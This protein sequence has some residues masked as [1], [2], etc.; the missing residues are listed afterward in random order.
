M[1]FFL[2]LLL[3]SY[4][5]FFGA[6]KHHQNAVLS[7]VE[8]RFLKS[9][10]VTTVNYYPSSHTTWLEVNGVKQKL[11]SSIPYTPASI[12]LLPSTTKS[13][14]VTKT[15][16]V[17]DLTWASSYLTSAEYLQYLRKQGYRELLS[18]QTSTYN[19]S[20]WELGSKVKRVLIQDQVLMVGYLSPHAL[21]PT[22]QSSLSSLSYLGGI[23]R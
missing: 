3:S 15:K 20:Y 2:L 16:A 12:L 8:F 13:F 4:F 9:G 22:L 5:Y 23:L 7:T 11:L 17:S 10:R 14:N 1:G 6:I 18:L 19:E 21:L